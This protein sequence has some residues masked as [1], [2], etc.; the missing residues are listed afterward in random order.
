MTSTF[1]ALTKQ[2]GY[3]ASLGRIGSLS[4]LE[5]INAGDVLDSLAAC[6]FLLGNEKLSEDLRLNGV[7]EISLL[8]EFKFSAFA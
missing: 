4:M 3:A 2:K 1:H 7:E 5:G 6:I 8:K